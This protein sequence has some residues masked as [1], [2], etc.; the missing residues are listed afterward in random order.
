VQGVE[1]P[2]DCASHGLFPSELL[3]HDLWWNGPNWL[4]LDESKWPKQTSLPPNSLEDEG[5]EICLHVVSSAMNPVVP[6]NKF[7]SFTR[8]KRVV[9]WVM[10][11]IHNCQSKK[12]N[13]S[14]ITGAPTVEELYQS[15]THLLSVLQEAHFSTEILAL[16]SKASIP[17]RSSVISLNPFLDEIQLL[18][19]GGREQNSKLPYY[20]QHP[21]I[22]HGGHPLSRLIIR[23]EHLRLLHAGPSL[24]TA[25]LCR[26]FHIIGGR[27][28]I[29]SV[30][31]SC[32]TCRRKASHP[33][34]QLMGQLP[35]ERVVPDAVFSNV[36]IDYAGPIYIKKG[37]VRKPTIVKA[38]VCVFVSL[39][40]KAV[41][42][43]TVSDLTTE[44]FVACLRRFIAR[45][46][47]P[48]SIWSDHGSNFV[49]AKRHL[50]ELY[51]FLKQS[52]TDSMITDF[53]STQ[54]IR[55]EFIPEQA[56]HFG[57]LWEAA[58]RTHL[59]RV[60]A[61]INLNFEELSTVL[62]QIEGMPQ[63]STS[64]QLAQ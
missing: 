21:I 32:V 30:I 51:E 10:R 61:N 57:G 33:Q 34:P 63:Q 37:A 8:L 38:Y 25:S 17:K 29:R 2:A 27:K 26:R 60:V 62:V 48:V 7:S 45:R 28:V 55:W 44:A 3:A 43:E 18:R 52:S 1:N 31:R 4:L 24:V 41:H 64:C 9:A 40:I 53:C 6:L 59:S 50:R 5:N 20:T 54:N 39:S 16:K 56:P 22:I 11:F 23:S 15:E 47:K 42:L 36:G 13:H 58:V 12:R 19:V 14:L 46:G 35:M 49:G